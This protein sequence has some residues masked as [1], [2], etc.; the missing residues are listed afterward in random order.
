MRRNS[1][2][3][4]A[5]SVFM[6]SL[7]LPAAATVFDFDDGTS[8]GWTVELLNP[9]GGPFGA[10]WSDI[11]NYPS[12]P[13]T[14]P[15]DGSNGSAFTAGGAWDGTDGFRI[16]QFISPDLTGDTMWQNLESFSGQLLPSFQ[17]ITP[18]AYFAN[19][20]LVIDDTH[21]RQRYRRW[22]RDRHVEPGV[23]HRHRHALGRY[24]CKQLYDKSGGVPDLLELR[25]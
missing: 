16:V 20:L 21:L 7:A 11:N 22:D 12:A 8:Q 24:G 3:Y 18:G 2:L 25:A 5:S 13:R 14:D 19:A 23:V 1:I 15:A 6:A 4:V 17:S 10:G 9:G